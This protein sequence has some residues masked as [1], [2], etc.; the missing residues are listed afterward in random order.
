MADHSRVIDIR[1]SRGQ[2]PVPSNSDGG[3]MPPNRDEA[4]PF[5]KALVLLHLELLRD[6]EMSERPE[7]LL[8]RAGIGIA[9]ISKMVNK[10]YMATAKAISRGKAGSQRQRRPTERSVE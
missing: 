1:P 8:Y 5:L 4:V 7:V 3:E 10:T 6:H 9:D 2:L